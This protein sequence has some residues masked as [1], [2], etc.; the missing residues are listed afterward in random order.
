MFSTLLQLPFPIV[1]R[2]LFARFLS[3]LFV[4][5]VCAAPTSVAQD[6]PAA[7]KNA[8][9]IDPAFAAPPTDKPEDD[10]AKMPA[11]PD[12]SAV[13]SEAAAAEMPAEN[14]DAVPAEED[15][16]ANP[17]APLS[18][19]DQAKVDELFTQAKQSIQAKE[20]KEAIESLE[21]ALAIA[22]GNGTYHHALGVAYMGDQQPN[23]GW[24][25]FR[26]AVRL[27]PDYVPA[28]VDFMKT[29]KLLDAQGVFNVGT[30]LPL[31]AQTLG[32][33]DQADDQGARLRLVYGF[34]SLNFMNS[35]LF[36]ILDMRN[37]PP[38]GLH[39]VD[40]LAFDLPREDWKVAYRILSAAQGNT[41][42][43]R[44]DENLQR[45]TELFAS[46]RFI[47]AARTQTAQ[48]VM[49]GIRS[50]LEKA[51]EDVEFTEIKATPD[52]V[53]FRW[54]IGKSASHPAQQELVRLVAGQ[55]D[56][57]RL[58]YTRKGESLDD[59]TLSDWQALLADAELMTAENLREYLAEEG[60][61][62]QEQQLREISVQILKKQFE[63]IRSGDV[64]ALKP[65]F[66]EDSRD[67]ITADLLKQ[68]AEQLDELDPAEMVND[69][70]LSISDDA[71]RARLLNKKGE[72]FTTLIQT[73]GRWFAE[74][75][76][77]ETIVK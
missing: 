63:L 17:A 71:A 54:S 64:E 34:M 15:E 38:D 9:E 27:N 37:L 52:D 58:A 62:Q 55:H 28:T 4:I 11:K 33:P 3:G 13:D 21:A 49:D 36:S 2:F 7:E 42:Y 74:Q 69:V 25:H 77:M 70:D 24:F 56:I 60:R 48:D 19:E 76:W 73:D 18:E 41:E 61:K 51:F 29:W 44:Q 66:T 59:D 39:A 16:Q 40:G 14:E 23:A 10:A 6:K 8:Q 5:L 1:S 20:W 22:P 75:V 30:P 12:T 53:F 43:V 50:R 72:V 46:Q 65:F 35:Q 45:W 31:V 57:H 26:Q 47:G 68:T 67:K 32:K